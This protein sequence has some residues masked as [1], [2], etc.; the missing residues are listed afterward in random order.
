MYGWATE[1][2]LGIILVCR[3]LGSLL[4]LSGDPDAF[5]APDAN[6]TTFLLSE[7]LFCN[8]HYIKWPVLVLVR[9]YLSPRQYK[10][11]S[12]QWELLLLLN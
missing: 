12:P 7:R 6:K 9:L 8:R 2:Y 4:L 10:I 11:I 1:Y 3:E 5:G